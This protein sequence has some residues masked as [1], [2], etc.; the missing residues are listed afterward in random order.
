MV[1]G[2]SCIFRQPIRVAQG[3]MFVAMERVKTNEQNKTIKSHPSHPPPPLNEEQS[4]TTNLYL[5]SGYFL[6][7]KVMA[8]AYHLT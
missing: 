7:L 5:R 3:K 4:L 2:V 8:V 6:K 1:E